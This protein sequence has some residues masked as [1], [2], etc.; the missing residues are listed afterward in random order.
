[1]TTNSYDEDYRTRAVCASTDPELFFETGMTRTAKAI[2]RNCPVTRECLNEALADEIA[3]GVWGGMSPPERLQLM[4]RDHGAK[5]RW[6]TGL[7]ALG[8]RT[9][10][11]KRGHALTE[12]NI[13]TTADGGRRCKAC[14]R[15]ADAEARDR[16]YARE[17]LEREAA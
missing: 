4:R 17:R 9:H 10:C 16:R 11:A 15:D 12:D 7:T 14:K 6:P 2:C 3:Y 13:L 5:Y 1:M 8:Q